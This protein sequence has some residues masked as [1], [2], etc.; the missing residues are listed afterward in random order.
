MMYVIINVKRQF[1]DVAGKLIWNQIDN[2]QPART[3]L[4]KEMKGEMCGTARFPSGKK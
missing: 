1:T 3:W 2:A 4:E